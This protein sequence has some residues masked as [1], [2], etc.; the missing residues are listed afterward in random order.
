M[1]T[2]DIKHRTASI[3]DTIAL[4]V[5]CDTCDECCE[6]ASGSGMITDDFEM[7]QIVHCP[8]CGTAYRL[9]H[10]AFQVVSQSK[11]KEV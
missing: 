3:S 8:T 4:T 1:I 2:Q 5:I 10:D 9:P 7:P 11:C 6:N